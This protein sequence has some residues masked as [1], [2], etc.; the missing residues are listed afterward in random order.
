LL[1][2]VRAVARSVD[3]SRSAVLKLLVALVAPEE[4]S[5]RD[6]DFR[7]WWAERHA[8]YQTHGTRTLIHP[9]TGEYPL[10]WQTLH[11]AD[12]HQTLMVM[13]APAG[14]RSLEVLRQLDSCTDTPSVLPAGSV[15]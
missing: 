8:N 12:E 4:V 14:S 9:T 1:R 5:L 3:R 15:D 10:D 7:T 6:P 11:T 2:L 13:T